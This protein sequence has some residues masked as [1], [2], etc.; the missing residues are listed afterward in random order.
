[1]APSRDPWDGFT[2]DERA[3]DV[4]YRALVLD[5]FLPTM[6]AGERL[7]QSYHPWVLHIGKMTSTRAEHAAEVVDTAIFGTGYHASL[8]EDWS[9]EPYV[10]SQAYYDD[11]APVHWQVAIAP[12]E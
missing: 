8:D 1:M 9:R 6:V 12:D 3:A 2:D 11:D 5:G 10:G 7:G 4:A